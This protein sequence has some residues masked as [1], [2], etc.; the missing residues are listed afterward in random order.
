MQ[1]TFHTFFKL[2]DF[3]REYQQKSS[4]LNYLQLHSLEKIYKE[5]AMKTLEISKTLQIS[6][7]TL[8]GVLDE[9]ERQKLI[10]RERQERDKRVV[11]VTVTNKGEEVVKKHFE[12]DEKFLTN[13][14]KELGEDEQK[15]L[16]MLLDKITGNIS[17]PEELFI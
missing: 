13:L 3:K 5:K 15:H 6:P 4:G 1:K 8:I 17:E 2:I 11:L 16:I 10:L 9:L 14:L 12:E 7:S